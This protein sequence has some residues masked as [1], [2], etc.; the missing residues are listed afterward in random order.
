[1]SAEKSEH[2]KGASLF[3]RLKVSSSLE[4]KQLFSYISVLDGKIISLKYILKE[5][6]QQFAILSS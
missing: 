3:K 4:N 1:M 5:T 2:R 6:I